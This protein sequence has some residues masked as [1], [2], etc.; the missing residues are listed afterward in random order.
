MDFSVYWDG[1]CGAE[2]IKQ[3]APKGVHGFILGMTLLFGK[4]RD[5]REIMKDIR[6]MQF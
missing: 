1:A 2:K 4:K 3:F 5:Y 6:E